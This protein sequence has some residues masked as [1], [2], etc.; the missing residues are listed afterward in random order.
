MTSST[1]YKGSCFC[2]SVQFELAGNP[3]AMAYCHCNSCRHWSAS[4]VSAFTLWKPEAMKITRGA[5]QISSFDKNPGTGDET[6][7][8]QR[9]WC[10][11]CGGHLFTDHPTMGLIDVPAVVI[12]GLEFKPGFHVH[13]QESVHRVKDG[14]P[15]FQDLPLEA[16]GSGHE[17]AE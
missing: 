9:K 4:P 5:E 12:E 3:E 2:G 1:A 13:Y 10:R 6:V 16:G 11:D 8:S 7:V 15:K 14:L 17:L